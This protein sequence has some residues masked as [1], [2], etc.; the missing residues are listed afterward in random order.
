MNVN[1]SYEYSFV[2]QARRELKE[3]ENKGVSKLEKL[4]DLRDTK[5]KSFRTADIEKLMEKYD[6]KAFDEYKKVAYRTD[7]GHTQSGLRFLS[8]WMDDVKAKL[9]EVDASTNVETSI[10]N[11]EMEAVLKEKDPELLEQL[12]SATSKLWN[13]R[14]TEGLSALF[15]KAMDY[16]Y[17]TRKENEI[18]ASKIN[19]ISSKNE[20][21]L[22]KKAQEF[23]KN[24]RKKYGDYDFM[25]GNGADELK[26]LSKSGSK[27]FSVILSSAEIERMANDEK[28]AQEKMDGIQGAVKM[29]KRICEEN[30]YTSGFG[31]SGENGSINKIGVTVDDKGNMKLFAELEKTSSKQKERIEKNREKRAEEKKS[32]D[33]TRKKNPYEKPEKPIIKRATIE[34]DSEEDL[35]NKISKFDW[36]SVAESKSGD[37]IDFSA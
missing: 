7:G 31:G 4:E 17:E 2:E 27:E 14:N 15:K 6:P 3:I 32:A 22:S 33:K 20:E 12:K 8:H 9:K 37:R 18:S 19:D 29:C 25:I 11:E 26:S 34:A 21:K 16:V 23:L 13:E 36:D 5:G 30:G 28:Y 24:L 35:L 10:G 1:S